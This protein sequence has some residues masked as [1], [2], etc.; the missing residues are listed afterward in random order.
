VNA[1]KRI[2]VRILRS[3]LGVPVRH[4]HNEPDDVHQDQSAEKVNDD[5]RVEFG[6][7]NVEA[8][9]DNQG[10]KCEEHVVVVSDEAGRY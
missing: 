9:E 3:G 5:F 1:R 7:L 4:D 2:P 6:V 8:I 10:Q